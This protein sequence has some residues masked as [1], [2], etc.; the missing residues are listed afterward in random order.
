[1]C[2]YAHTVR[3]C[4][5]NTGILHYSSPK[6]SLTHVRSP[7]ALNADRYPEVRVMLCIGGIDPKPMYETL[8]R[9]LHAV[10]ATPGRLKVGVWACPSGG[11]C[12][13]RLVTG[14]SRPAPGALSLALRISMR[15]CFGSKDPR[16]TAECI[17]ARIGRAHS[18]VA[19]ESHTNL[20]LPQLARLPPKTHK[21]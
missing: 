13:G 8:R 16:E 21:L 6:R 20:S 10:V 3:A 14:R 18:Y 19:S 1:M 7:Q 11:N 5:R 17:N 4:T 9:G 12:W 2:V 15:A